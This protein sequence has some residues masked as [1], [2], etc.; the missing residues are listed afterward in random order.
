MLSIWFNLVSFHA[1]VSGGEVVRLKLLFA[2]GTD[3]VMAILCSTV[4]MGSLNSEELC[5]TRL[6]RLCRL[7]HECST[8]A[9]RRSRGSYRPATMLASI[10]AAAVMAHELDRP[11]E[12]LA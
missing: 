11:A 6:P 5:E 12:R 8:N 9:L 4:S 10:I 7:R 3:V 1:T 2:S